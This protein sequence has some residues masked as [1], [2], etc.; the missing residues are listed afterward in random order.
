MTYIHK[1][2]AEELRQLPDEKLEEIAGCA[3]GD[4]EYCSECGTKTAFVGACGYNNES[5][6]HKC[7][8]TIPVIG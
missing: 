3:V 5:S 1:T 2:S 6:C 7:G 8:H 4:I